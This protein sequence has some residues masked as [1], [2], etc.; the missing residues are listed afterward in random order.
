MPI[1]DTLSIINPEIN[2]FIQTEMAESGPCGLCHASTLAYCM[3]TV[4]IPILDQFLWSKDI[5]TS[6]QAKP[7]RAADCVRDVGESSLAMFVCVGV[8]GVVWPGAS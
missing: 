5:K 1:L 3:H 6:E 8:V 4:G 2:A 7:K